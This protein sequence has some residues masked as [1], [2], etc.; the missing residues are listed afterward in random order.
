MIDTA[1][2]LAVDEQMM[3]E[4]AAVKEAINPSETLFLSNAKQAGAKILNGES[5]LKEQALKSWEIWT[6]I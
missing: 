6:S 3:N 4:I 5:M 2:R 1:G